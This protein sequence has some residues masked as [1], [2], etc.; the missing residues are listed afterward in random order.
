MS[1]NSA[2]VDEIWG[3]IKETREEIKQTRKQSR[4][5]TK[6]TRI[7][8]QKFRTGKEKLRAIQKETAKQ[9]KKTD[10]RFNTQWG[11]LVES[12]V[13]GSLV[14]LLKARGI[15]VRQTSTNVQVSSTWMMAA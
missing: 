13:E 8:M 12:L 7:E 1:N 6:Q 5:Y 4:D 14:S 15:V 3:L 2:G 10:K 11:R 9:L